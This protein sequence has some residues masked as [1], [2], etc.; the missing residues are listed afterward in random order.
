MLF[1]SHMHIYPAAS[2]HGMLLPAVCVQFSILGM[3]IVMLLTVCERE[4][5]AFARAVVSVVLSECKYGLQ[6]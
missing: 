4:A 1:A 6:G 5:D 3:S 2:S